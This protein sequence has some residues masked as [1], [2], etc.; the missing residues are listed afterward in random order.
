MPKSAVVF[1]AYGTL[2]D[3]GAAARRAAAAPGRE[4]LSAAEAELSRVWREKQVGYS[5]WRAVTGDYASFW[6]VT[7]DALDH[8]L[9]ATGLDGDPAL[10]DALL[11]LYWELAAYPEVP[12]TLA[13]LRAEGRRT[14]I[15][16][17]G[18]PD[19]LAGA[20]AAASLGDA[21]DSVISVEEVAT[22]KPDRRVYDLVDRHL[23]GMPPGAVLFV[24]ANGWDAAAAAGYGFETAWVNRAGAAKDRLPHAPHHE[25][26]DLRAVPDLA[27]A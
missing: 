24:S 26:G 15:L 18:S 3:V 10:R 22:F 11:T 17:N 16:S 23:G 13:R 6:Q 27:A 4:R 19:M 1:D 5:W 21:L 8:A 9:E 25:I 12:E 7:Q 2:F 20:V 14:A